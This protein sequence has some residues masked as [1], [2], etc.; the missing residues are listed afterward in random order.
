M[1]ETMVIAIVVGVIIVIGI[2]VIG[3]RLTGVSVTAGPLSGKL[4]GQKPGASVTDSDFRG[5]RQSIEA[6]GEGGTIHKVKT[7]GSD[8]SVKADTGKP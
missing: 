5:E 8:I 7:D 2:I 3:R 1:S 6:R 4:D